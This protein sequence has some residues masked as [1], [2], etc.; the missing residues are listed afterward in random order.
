MYTSTK[1]IDGFS[2][3][4]RQEA[5]APIHCA[6]LHGYSISFEVEFES[7]TLDSRNWVVDFGF[8]KRSDYKLK[9]ETNQGKELELNLDQ[10]FKYMFDHT[11]VVS[12]NDSE[13]L[14]FGEA[15]ERQILQLR[16]VDTVGCEA[17]AKLVYDQ[18]WLFLMATRM[19]EKIT[20]KKVT[21]R[22]NENNSA[23][24]YL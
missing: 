4:F 17:F 21:C 11:V 14:W 6:L 13:L 2:T 15:E 7:Q 12:K 24:Y 3:C 23:S 1:I 18:L 5:A 16:I 22:E 20:I 10:W 9:V 19:I 8:L